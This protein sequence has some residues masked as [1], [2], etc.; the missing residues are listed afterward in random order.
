MDIESCP[1]LSSAHSSAPSLVTSRTGDGAGGKRCD[2]LA[3]GDGMVGEREV[4]VRPQEPP[5]LARYTWENMTMGIM[6]LN[7]TF[8]HGKFAGCRKRSPPRETLPQGLP[9]SSNIR[10]HETET[11]LLPLAE[12]RST[13][14]VVSDHM[15]PIP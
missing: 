6:V 10:L 13:G 4:G 12:W 11:H 5:V 9:P 15:L 14:K 2:F 7:P 8:L 3:K 1:C